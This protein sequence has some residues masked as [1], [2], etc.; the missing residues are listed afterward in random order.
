MRRIRLSQVLDMFYSSRGIPVVGIKLLPVSGEANANLAKRFSTRDDLTSACDRRKVLQLI[1]H[2]ALQQETWRLAQVLQYR[3][4]SMSVDDA[5]LRRNCAAAVE[6]F[7]AYAER[8]VARLPACNQ[9]KEYAARPTVDVTLVLD[10][11]RSE[12]ESLEL[13]R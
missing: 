10:G 13:V 1:D 7:V 4:S 8:L 2:E 9:V 6:R 3:R 12:Y 5:S 11:A